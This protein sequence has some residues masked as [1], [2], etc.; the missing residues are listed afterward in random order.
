MTRII[1]T[2]SRIGFIGCM[3]LA[4]VFCITASAE[5]TCQGVPLS[6]R[7]PAF[8]LSP[9]ERVSGI[10]VKTSRGTLSSSCLPSRWTC[11][12][13]GSSI[14]CYSR[15]PSY[16]TAMTGRLPEILVRDLPNDGR[17]LGIEASVEYLGGDGSVSTKDVR[18][19][20]LIIQ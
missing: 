15:H 12:H 16:A 9:G 8:S 1:V 7:F 13:K 4:A 2:I 17:T 5:V 10:T 14:H 3:L 18:I 11:D 20:D 19:T 6:I